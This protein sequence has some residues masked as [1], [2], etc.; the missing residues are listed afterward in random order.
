MDTE[1]LSVFKDRAKTFLRCFRE[2]GLSRKTPMSV[3]KGVYIRNFEDC[4]E[5]IQTNSQIFVVHH[6]PN[7]VIHGLPDAGVV[8]PQEFFIHLRDFGATEVEISE[9]QIQ[10][11]SSFSLPLLNLSKFPRLPKHHFSYNSP[12]IRFAAS[13][14]SEFKKKDI[15][16]QN[17]ITVDINKDDSH[18]FNTNG[19]KLFLMRDIKGLRCENICDRLRFSVP[20]NAWDVASLYSAESLTYNLG[21]AKF[22]SC[23]IERTQ[24]LFPAELSS[25]HKTDHLFNLPESSLITIEVLSQA[26]LNGLNALKPFVKTPVSKL[27]GGIIE[28]FLDSDSLILRT[29]ENTAEVVIPRKFREDIEPFSFHLSHSFLLDAVQTINGTVVLKTVSTN[30]DTMCSPVYITEYGNPNCFHITMSVKR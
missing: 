20:K 7:S 16:T 30:K 27:N 3:L 23:N 1:I 8:L 4:L 15:N 13:V 25:S 24:V 10:I 18:I 22:Q 2:L 19:S 6:F 17:N 9:T 26:L 21:Q 5:V 28:V 12:N 14:L 29:P 11:D